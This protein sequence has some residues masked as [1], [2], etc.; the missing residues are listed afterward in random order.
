MDGIANIDQNYTCAAYSTNSSAIPVLIGATARLFNL[1]CGATI[2]PSQTSALPPAV[3]EHPFSLIPEDPLFPGGP[4]ANMSG[5]HYFADATTPTF[6]LN[7]GSTQYGIT[8]SK[9]ATK[10]AAPV[11]PLTNGFWPYTDPTDPDAP[12]V[13]NTTSVPWVKLTAQTAPAV[14]EEMVSENK[15][16]V[17]E[18]YRI[19]TAGGSP[20]KD[21]SKFPDGGHLELPYAAE[22]W[23][24]A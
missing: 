11:N 17:I 12:L 7:M 22:Y 15:G 23:F 3:V 8:F 16:G 10:V 2:A 21:C 6:N 18:V 13:R 19:N 9:L 4:T 14:S 20:P 5:Y 1:S 24:F